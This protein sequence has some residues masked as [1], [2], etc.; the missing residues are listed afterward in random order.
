VT[1]ILDTSAVLAALDEDQ[2]EH[3]AVAMVLRTALRSAGGERLVV[4]P[5]VVA[6]AD[7]MLHIRLGAAAARAFAR[8][9]AAEAYELASWDAEDHAVAVEVIT[10]Y[11]DGYV[12][13]TDAANVVLADRYRTTRCSLSISDTSASCGRSGARTPSPSYPST[14]DPLAR[15]GLLPRQGTARFC[16]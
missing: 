1:I 6:E 7:Y 5:M 8:D 13:I 15:R 14:A 11:R 4:S 3:H 2:Q 16:L 12:G 10:G 9:V